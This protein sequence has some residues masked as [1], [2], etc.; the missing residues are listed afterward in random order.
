M[1]KR[2]TQEQYVVMAMQVH[3]ADDYDYSETKYVSMHDKILVRC[4]THGVFEQQ[5]QAHIKGQ[6]CPLC[7]REKMKQ[8]LLVNYGVDNPMKCKEIQDKA[9][10]TCLDRYGNE[11]VLLSEAGKAKTIETLQSKYGVSHVSQS[12][13]IKAK[14][15]ATM[16][17]RYGV[18][19]VTETSMFREKGRQTCLERY[20]TKEPLASAV[21][22]EKIEK[23]NEL[24]YG[25]PAPMCSAEVRMKTEATVFEKYGVP[26][27]PQARSVIEKVIE[28]KSVNGTFGTSNP[29]EVLYQRLCEKFGSDDVIRQYRSKVYPY[30]CDFYVKSRNMYIELNGTW[31]H[32]G[33]WF[34]SEDVNDIAIRNLWTKR[35]TKYYRNA[36]HVWTVADL[37][38]KADAATNRL[39]YIVF[40][41]YTLKDADIWFKLGCPDGH[42]WEHEYSWLDI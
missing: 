35:G 29:E 6:G 40:W 32:G 1:P 39:N 28:S 24:R 10:Q 11:Y 27:A 20:G 7:G 21:I 41:G 14:I 16:L 15:E 9:R 17:Q 8:S 18:R 19:S 23:T 4:R 13:A 33:H 31:T 38:K 36:V 5:A 37:Q 25:G 12:E 42:D 2:I 26:K 3:A 34:D 30:P 22:R